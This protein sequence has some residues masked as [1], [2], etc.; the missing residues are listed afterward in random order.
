MPDLRISWLDGLATL[1]PQQKGFLGEIL[2]D[3]NR[4]LLLTGCAGSGK[5][6][7]AIFVKL[8]LDKKFPDKNSLVLVYTKALE[9]FIID[10]LKSRNAEIIANDI[11]H[12]NSWGWYHNDYDLIIVDEVQDFKSGW[13]EDVKSYSQYQIWMGDT[14]QWIYTEAQDTGGYDNLIN[15]FASKDKFNFDVNYRNTL[16]IAKF[17]SNFIQLNK[18][19]EEI[20]ISLKEKRKKFIEPITKNER[21]ISEARNQPVFFIEAEDREKEIDCIVKTIEY[22]QNKEEESK[23]IAIVQLTH[24]MDLDIIE[25][26]LSNRGY[27]IPRIPKENKEFI[28]EMVNF[29]DPD[30]VLLSTAHSLKGLEFDYVIYPRSDSFSIHS[31]APLLN[32]YFMLFARAKTG[33]YCSYVNKNNSL[34][35]KIVE[36]VSDDSYYKILKSDEFLSLELDNEPTYHDEDLPF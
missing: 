5:T 22:I 25:K 4:K 18:Y 26:G 24:H 12:Y 28:L 33:I 34:V 30:L 3:P 21:Q 6:L 7:M 9:K 2:R 36:M 29:T 27:E 17:A 32:I 8:I 23:Q 14:N 11:D 16:N 15:E 13:I 1:S 20:G 31:K 19:D 10:N 35:Y